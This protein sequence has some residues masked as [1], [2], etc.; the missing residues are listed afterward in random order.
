MAQNASLKL[1]GFCTSKGETIV[2]NL[3]KS[4]SMPFHRTILPGLHEN[5][6]VQLN[7]PPPRLPPVRSLYVLA[8]EK[9]KSE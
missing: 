1:K 6:K 7:L 8:S 3:Y 9:K 4:N 5:L 2:F